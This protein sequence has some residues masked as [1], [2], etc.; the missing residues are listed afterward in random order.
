MVSSLFGHQ[1]NHRF[2]GV[3]HI[4][5]SCDG[6]SKGHMVPC[7][8]PVILCQPIPTLGRVTVYDYVIDG[9][10]GIIFL[11]ASGDSWWCSAPCPD[12]PLLPDVV[13]L[14]A[15]SGAMGFGAKF[16]GG[17][18]Q[19]SVDHNTLAVQ[20]LQANRHGTILQLDLT[21][22]DSAKHIHQACPGHVGTILMG[23]PCQPFSQQG[24]RFGSVDLRF[25][26]SKLE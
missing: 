7:L 13:E 16:G 14:C 10:D 12:A 1:H 5:S 9:D 22:L 4:S 11:N 6:I 8:T 15:G 3:L 23:F 24:S 19:V 20:H 2:T 18:I 17:K 26:I 21:D 25:F